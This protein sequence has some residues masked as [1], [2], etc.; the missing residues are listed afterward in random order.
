MTTPEEELAQAEQAS[1]G[2]SADVD[3]RLEQV[4]NAAAA[5]LGTALARHRRPACLSPSRP[6]LD[7]IF[8]A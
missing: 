3:A 8:F 2:P 4:L 6:R 7:R 1:T 5:E